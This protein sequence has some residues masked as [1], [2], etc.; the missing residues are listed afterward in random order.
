MSSKHDGCGH[1]VQLL[2]SH[3]NHIF[4]ILWEVGA[5]RKVLEEHTSTLYNCWSISLWSHPNS[6]IHSLLPKTRHC[7]RKSWASTLV[8]LLYCGSYYFELI[9]NW[10]NHVVSKHFEASRSLTTSLK[11]QV[12]SDTYPTHIMQVP[13]LKR[14]K[15]LVGIAKVLA[16]DLYF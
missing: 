1:N 13:T 14:S 16:M 10:T 15:S 12:L 11:L 2:M 7:W 3:T 4:H 9:L 8:L 6:Y 5:E